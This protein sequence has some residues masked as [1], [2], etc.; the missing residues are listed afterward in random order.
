VDQI[1]FC[2]QTVTLEKSGSGIP[3]KYCFETLINL[4]SNLL[5]PPPK[6]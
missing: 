3:P 1:Y 5:R 2:A 6:A 4:I